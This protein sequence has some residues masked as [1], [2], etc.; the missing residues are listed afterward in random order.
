MSRM[1]LLNSP[2]LLGFDEVLL[3][4]PSQVVDDCTMKGVDLG[5]RLAKLFMAD[6]ARDYL[7]S[8]K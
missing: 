2:L 4:D 3:R 6:G 7:A 8:Y 5:V 1:S